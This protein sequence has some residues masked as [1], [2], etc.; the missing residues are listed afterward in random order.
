MARRE[1]EHDLQSMVVQ[2]WRLTHHKLGVPERLLFAIPNGGLRNR[3]VAAKL[4]AEGVRAGVPDMMLAVPRGAA[5]GLFIEHKAGK[6]KPSD[7]QEGVISDLVAQGYSVAVSH[8]YDETVKLISSYLS[9]G[10]NA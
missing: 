8:S 9:Q 5:H 6:R 7:E 10:E 2:W 4:K 1:P 3:V